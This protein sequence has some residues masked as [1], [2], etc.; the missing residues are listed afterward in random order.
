[1]RTSIALRGLTPL[2]PATST[3]IFQHTLKT[4]VSLALLA[5]LSAN[6]YA[7][8]DTDLDGIF[9]SVDIDDDN[10]GILDTVEGCTSE[11]IALEYVQFPNH[12]SDAT[13]GALLFDGLDVY[14][15]NQD[16]RFHDFG[17]TVGDLTAS[18]LDNS[19]VMG[20]VGGV[21][22]LPAGSTF[23]LYMENDDVAGDNAQD[24]ADNLNADLADLGL[25]PLDLFSGSF[26]DVGIIG[27][28]DGPDF[29][30]DGDGDI[31]T[32]GVDFSPMGVIIQ[33]YD[34]NP[35]T[36]GTLI[37]TSFSDIKLYDD[38]TDPGYVGPDGD[39]IITHTATATTA[40]THFV[41]ASVP[42][43]TGLDIRV[44]EI[45]LNG[46]TNTG[47][48]G[49][50][51][52]FTTDTDGDG[53]ADCYDLDSDNDG[54]S[55][56]L[57]S[58]SVAG[59]LADTNGDG[60]VSIAEANAD[61]SATAGD[62][63]ITNNG[64]MDVFGLAD[65]GTTPQ[66]SDADAIPNYLDLDSDNDTIP[67]ATEARATADYVAYPPVVD[68]TADTDDDG[69]LD[70][71]D[72]GT[73][74]GSL[75]TGFVALSAELNDDDA[76]G[77]PDYL[78]DDSDGDGLLDSAEA[79]TI[80]GVAY[81]DPDGDVNEPLTGS[82]PNVDGDPSDTDFRS[83]YSSDVE[84]LKTLITSA[85]YSSGDTVTYTILV[86]NNGVSDA[87]NV[88][89]GD[90]ETGLTI[91]GVSVTS[92]SGTCTSFNC[93]IGTLT[94]GSS[95]T[96]TVN[97]TIDAIATGPGT[98]TN[99]ATVT[100]DQTDPDNTNNDSTVSE[101]ACAVDEFQNRAEAS[102]STVD[103]D[104][105]NNASVT[106]AVVFNPSSMTVTK[107]TA[108]ASISAPGTINYTIVVV[109]T[110]D[111]A[112]TNIMPSDTLPDASAG[113]LTGPTETG[114]SGTNGDNI[115][116]IGETW[117]YTTSFAA[118]QAHI[119]AGTNLTNTISVTTDEIT[120]P[121]VDTA[122]TTVT[123]T[124]ELTTTK[125]SDASG[126]SS[127]AVVGDI[128]VYTV[129][130]ENTGNVQ[131]SDMTVTDTQLG[132]DIT[133]SCVFP[134]DALTGLAPTETVTCTVNYPITQADI[135]AGT[136]QNTAVGAGE[137]PT[138]SPVSDDSDSTNPADDLGTPEDPTNTAIPQDPELTTTKGSD[139][140]GLSSPAV[141]GDIIVYTV[142]VENT[143][144]VQVS[145][146]TVTDTQL[147][148]DITA[149]CVFPVD[150]LTGL[151]PTETVTCTVN[152]P[153]TQVDI[154]AGT[155]QN[156]AVGAGEDPTGS[157]V[158]DDSDSTNP[159]DDLGT[160]E[161][162]TNTAIPQDPELTTT[163]GSDA[164]GL[165]SPA[166]VGDII[167]Y[168]VTVENTGNVQVSDM[169]VTDT[170][171]GGDITASCVFPVDAL[172][173]LAPTETVTCTVNYPITQV[174]ID[175]GTVQ[176]TAVG[177][178]EDPTGS[179]VSDDSDS[180][181]PADDLGTPE[182][183]TNT[184]IPQDPELTTTK[185][186][187]ASGLSSPAV[188]GD[189]IVYTVTVENTGNVQVSDMTVTDTQL[190]GDITAS[191][192][193][194]VDA[195]T[196]L[197]PTE[198]VTCTV[199]Y[200]ITQADIDAGTVQNTAV[201]A[202]EDPTGSPVSDDSDS[203]NPAD[204]LGTP[205]DPTNTAIPQ[206]PELTTTKGSD[207]SGLSSPA[208]VGDIIVYTVT[209]E[210]TG[211][212]QVSDMT[213][214]DT[215]LGGDITAS[216]VFPVDALTG[217]APT[218]TVTCTVNYPITQADIDAGTVQN[219]AVG[220]G[221]DPTGSPVSD[222]SDSTNPADDLGTPED[223]TNTAIPQ[224]PELTTTKGSDASGLSSPAVV[225]DI[226]VYTVT[227]ENTGNVQVSDMT[228][229]D[230][231]LGGDITASCVF[232]VDALTGL[233]PT[234]TVTCTVNYPI[235]QA[236]IDAGTVQNTAVGAGED[237]TGS[238]VS[239]DSDSTNPA[240]DLGTPEDPTNTAIPQ[241]PE[242][243]TTKGSDASGL[244][245]PAVAGDII[246]YTVTV[247]NT[248]NV[249]VSDMTVTDTQLGGD[250]TA[251]CVFPVDA[252][253]GLAPTETV[254]CTVNY[255]ITQVDIDAGTVQ[256]TAVGAGEDPTGSPV[257]DD[258]DSTN[259]ADDLGT[260]EDP[261]N[262][263]IPQDPELTTTKGS[264]ASGLS[265]PAV[266]G[267][268]IVY[269]VTVE[270][271]GNVQV[272]DMT[273]TDTQL[274]G[275]ITAS[276]VFPVDALTGLAPTETVTC[277]V[278][279]P[280]TQVDIDAGTVQNTAVGAG[281]DPTGSPVSDDSDSTNPADDL[282]TPEDPT[283]T[284]IPQ[285]P[286]LTTTKGSDASGLSSPA[287]VG[288]IIVYTVTV[289]NTGN[290]QVSDM[291]VTDTQLGG[292]ITASC[293]FPVDALTGL[294]PT[295]TVTCTVNYPITQ[296]DIDAGTVQ[297]T[298][299]GAGEDP[300]GS[301]VSDDSDSTNPADDL[302]TPEDP[303]NTA[304]PQDPELTTTKGSDASGLSSPAVVGDIIVY[305]VT[306]ENTGN[307]QVSD[308]T[309]TDT[310]L[311]GDITASCV[312][313]V[314]ALT[315]LAPTETVTCTVNYPITQADIDAGTVQN[316]AVGAGEDPTG[317]PVSDDSDSTN[318][319]D[320]LG[321]PEDPT[322]TAIPQDPE[323]TTTKGSD[324]SGLSSPAV[325]GDIIVYTVTVE[326]TGNVQVSDMTVTDTQL[327]GDITASCVFPVDALTG[328]APTETVTC[329]VNYPITQADIDAG[330]VQNTAVG[331]GEDPT[332]S[333]VSDDSDSTNPADDLGTP[334][335][336]T[337][338]AIPQDPELTTTKGSDASGLSSPAVVG[339]II[340][341]TVT[342]ENTG[343][344]QVSDMTVTDTQLGGDITASCVFP[345]DALTG[346]AP[347]E[348]V[349]CTVNY[350]I[351]QADMM[352][353]Q[354]RTPRWVQ[355]KTPLDLQ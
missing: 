74:F 343:N 14:T 293:V 249:Q 193:F 254:T 323:L 272:S 231:Q 330:T 99:T 226:I 331:A 287:V 75:N 321:T 310:Q 353:A 112:L 104:G 211:N 200:P 177:A 79:G 302:G 264:D 27:V 263:A 66:N 295:E 251:S 117:T 147:G 262:T 270:N 4:I 44:N 20:T 152:Y 62:G 300:T 314:D 296:A 22:Q 224:D 189:I 238:P 311:G 351:T 121:E 138:G 283:N 90:S 292:D 103:S 116:D 129:T 185:G 18:I 334:E 280:I 223:P 337:N 130:V 29:D 187:D 164:S 288:D 60:T 191:C 218:E 341:Y 30:R 5:L 114:G 43:G 166:V 41:V 33:F 214:T 113:P 269:T 179:P 168:T 304:I 279:Y 141:A 286:E 248:G 151:A 73:G 284:A 212:V 47:V 19:L 49:F 307:V 140:S 65:I 258:S 48:L 309:V 315:G 159:A 259:P 158:S 246:V 354:C 111:V 173:G 324:A 342:V 107:T 2:P 319:A 297:N 70:I 245:S 240:D 35:L 72:T 340:V 181:N 233:A 153:I 256:N 194:P 198:T 61:P 86:T 281:E 148:G 45:V 91:T 216:C 209:V 92:G 339:D 318:P 247:E 232:P 326:N 25:N 108:T 1:M 101:Q 285:D 126:L 139:A 255:P 16:L 63:D 136:V 109:N 182:D 336:P 71:Y 196:G 157:P 67:D 52:L 59:A 352:R 98:F 221:E 119:D 274:G 197:A 312:F 347:T 276:C 250:I 11:F 134:V 325:V 320:E 236:D 167:V 156:T 333:P 203:T 84:I 96:I 120:T 64:L 301:P 290:V 122:I 178:G 3:K 332:G 115:L 244:S 127:P 32:E 145:D 186:S 149:S 171:L 154:D 100:A 133:A 6:S 132:G 260:P 42:D 128:I 89:V 217:L 170:Q 199:N 13:N 46:Q 118:D 306:V 125:G 282:G 316:T 53:I 299:V 210:N 23:T 225:G 58:G 176:N 190:G 335:D 82:L 222:D 77:L 184:A 24:I 50:D 257:S 21:A 143:G 192:V 220:A 317:S 195:L 93:N 305:T 57:E 56:L 175:A 267:D 239:D 87:T 131:V 345:V 291:T 162:P 298:A 237:P 144:N 278:N 142:T 234:E 137:D 81:S 303:T 207:A 105:T 289:E 227:V 55:D 38:G 102:S 235:T 253:T 85:P 277:T 174:D 155:V 150:A 243:T 17:I 188:V 160:P 88:M 8:T 322:N 78:D 12:L 252:L 329:T 39:G 110:G 95:T 31:D 355:V 37:D 308:M 97:A 229:T 83:V 201:G 28:L 135:D 106:C 346:L 206:D 228:V 15:G 273:V 313:P 161:D 230:T 169:T 76:A 268:I 34:G 7:Q 241:D 54:I 219:T 9:D 123:Q 51:V 215:Q 183:P 204:D 265:S 275:D 69:I 261:T 202:G 36:G 40:F 10:D 80:S 180:T 242:L 163:K 350:P 294:A 26:T 271:T 213:V 124:P 94:N 146:M 208:V 68:T 338:T 349:T 172:T 344:V 327:G 348:T 266:V 205:E 165:S 328:L